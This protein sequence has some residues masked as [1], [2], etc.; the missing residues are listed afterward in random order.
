MLTPTPTKVPCP[1]PDCSGMVIPGSKICVRCAGRLMQCP[2]GHVMAADIGFCHVCGYE[3]ISIV[4]P[5]QP[6]AEPL[7]EPNSSVKV[8]SIL[9]TSDEFIRLIAK[10]YYE[11]ALGNAS[12]RNAVD[13][14]EVIRTAII[15]GQNHFEVWNVIDQCIGKVEDEQFQKILIK[16]RSGFVQQ[17]LTNELFR[18]REAFRGNPEA[19]WIEWLRAYTA[20]FT[21][22]RG[23]F[24]LALSEER[25]QFPVGTTSVVEKIRRS[26]KYMLHSR[27]PETYNMII[28]LAEQE[29]IPNAHRAK[30]YVTAAEIQL[31]HLENPNKAKDLLERGKKLDPGESR[32]ICGCGEYC[33]EQN[34]FDKAKEYFQEAV[35][36]NP[37]MAD[38]YVLMGDYYER[39]GNLDAAEEW[40][41]AAIKNKCGDS[42]GYISLLRLYGRPEKFATHETDMLPL[43]N[44]SIAV[45]PE[46]EY[47]A[48]LTMGYTYQQNKQYEKAYYW[49]DKAIEL[50]KTRLDA[51]ISKG[52]SYVEE[53]NYEQ[54]QAAFQKAI[55]VA[56]EALDG[57]WGMAWLK[58]QQGQS[59]DALYWHEQS[60]QRRPSWEGRIRGRIG[61]IRLRLRQYEEAENELLKALRFEPD[62]QSVLRSLHDLAYDLKLNNANTAIRVYDEI[63]QIIGESYEANYHSNLAKVYGVLKDW[64]RAKEEFKTAFELDKNEDVFRREMAYIY[65]TEGNEHFNPNNFQEAIKKYEEAALWNPNESLYHLNLSLAWENLKVPGNRIEELENAITAL[66]KALELEPENKKY[67][68]RLESLGLKK[69]LVI[70]CGEPALNF[71]PILTPIAVELAHNLLPYILSSGTKE[72]SA[73]FIRLINAMRSRIQERFGVRIPGVRFREGI[74]MSGNYVFILMET[75]IASANTVLDKKFFPGRLEELTALEIAGEEAFNSTTGVAG[76]WIAQ[77]DW[78]KAKNGGL[79]LWEVNEYIL[80]HLEAVLQK[81]LVEFVDHQE[82][83]SILGYDETYDNIKNSPERFATLI[84]ILKKLVRE[85]VPITSLNSICNKFTSLLAVGIDAMNIVERLRSLPEILPSLPGNNDQYSFYQLS[86][87]FEV[88]IDKSISEENILSLEPEKA[89]DI[90]KAVRDKVGSEKHVAIIV[91]KAKL[92]PFIKRLIEYE[93]PDIPIL[94]RQELLSGLEGKVIGVIDPAI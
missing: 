4:K 91:K 23:N 30:M 6:V 25:F 22:G 44:R 70:T 67:A 33:L 79:F 12:M 27:W 66:R 73:D 14:L 85:E 38:G 57:Y 83:M 75:P 34:K 81:N 50:E 94:S 1:Y 61:D 89:H 60:L 37:L 74:N 87:S 41:R 52:Y 36:Q 47:K 64:T 55:E 42:Q 21:Y 51:Y 18:L 13:A 84:E 53:K 15:D 28:Y 77:T 69:K 90:L 26:T 8:K 58:E 16:F 82:V 92:R 10:A 5:V 40:Y 54:A 11:A 19:G 78:E 71:T 31:Y 65:N 80:R 62:N 93:F 72:L 63:R 24:C 43:L 39:Q 9:I 59:E 3:N 76:Y 7:L 20:S 88:T 46:G 68:G 2:Q 32:I 29:C 35:Y 86:K 17:V 56:P 48:Y 45:D 49:Y